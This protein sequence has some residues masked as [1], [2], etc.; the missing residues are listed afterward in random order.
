VAGAPCRRGPAGDGAVRL[1]GGRRGSGF[2]LG[3]ARVCRC[4]GW[5]GRRGARGQGPRG[6]AGGRKVRG[7]TDGSLAAG[8]NTLAGAAARGGSGWACFCAARGRGWGWGSVVPGLAAPWGHGG[9]GHTGAGGGGGLGGARRLPGGR[10]VGGHLGWPGGR[11]GRALPLGGASPGARR[12]CTTRDQTKAGPFAGAGGWWPGAAAVG[13]PW[14]PRKKQR[15]HEGGGGPRA[16]GPAGAPAKG[17]K[18]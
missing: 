15:A 13:W 4:R 3:G 9:W 17:F 2:A 8:A 12:W 14:V 10:S 6:W 1:P 16:A 7:G 11:R 18:L 5:R